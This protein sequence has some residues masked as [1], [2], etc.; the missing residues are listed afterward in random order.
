MSSQSTSPTSRSLRI[1]LAQLNFKV[2]DLDRNFERMRAHVE[3]S[4]EQG[5]DLVVFSECALLGYPPR[6]MVERDDLIAEQLDYL[7]RL[8]ELSDDD[9]GIVVGYIDRNDAHRGKP[10]RNAAALCHQGEVVGKIYK[11]LLPTYDVFDE[12]RYFEP[13]DEARL[14]DFKGVKLGICV[15]EDAWN[16]PDFWE[17][18]LYACDPV[19]ELADA[20]AELLINIAASPFHLHKGEFRRRL[21]ASHASSLERTV[22]F[23]NQIGG[24]DELIF[25]G[26]SLIVEPGGE[27]S[28]RLAEF[29]EDFAV[30]DV[31]LASDSPAAESSQSS[32]LAPATDDG[33]VQA[34]KAIVL[35]L[36][37]YFHKSGFD[38]AI[39]GVS[40]GIDSALT[41]ALAAE[42][43]GPE[44][45]LGVAMPTRYTRDISNE[46]AQKLADNL[47]IDFMTIPIE[48]SFRAFLEQMQPVFEGLGEDVTE[49]NVQA[50]IRGTTLMALSNKFGKLVLV[51]SNK[52]ELAVGYSTLYGDLVGALS[53]LGDCLKTL[54]YDMARSY[55]DE[56]GE[57]IIPTRTIER[58]PSAELR[59]D[60]TDQDAL[61]AYEVL[62]AILEAYMV[63]GLSAE[64]IVEQGFDA[65]VV[66]ETLKKVFRA[67]YKRWQ[68][69]PI[70]KVTEKAFGVGWRYPLAASYGK[71]RD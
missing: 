36:R 14:L 33:A 43:L 47:G 45:I 63:D 15:C 61:P 21:L 24:H 57:E 56:A 31:L 20:G 66:D 25:D 42:A 40:G 30:R 17:R 9:L 67:E 4:R 8:A 69:A 32:S 41:T 70:L 23:V 18:P 39:I 60:Q 46:D 51:P 53:P 44:N 27:V 13:G 58:P 26:R 49:E 50:R 28:C 59:P 19:R 11:R 48:S 64:A 6:D 22:I 7:D 38:G 54:V 2:G 16:E 55:N 1:A 62:D 5:A 35:G 29:A 65:Q 3:K 10:L 52:S 12:D 71:L 37:D 34:R 68:A